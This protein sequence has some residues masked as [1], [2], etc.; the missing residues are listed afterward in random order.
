MDKLNEEPI[1]SVVRHIMQ[2]ADGQDLIEYFQELSDDNYESFKRS[3][4]S[5]NDIHKGYALCIDNLIEVFKSYNKTNE[6]KTT[7]AID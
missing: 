2:S 1:R 4:S 3:D 7:F 6:N 5:M